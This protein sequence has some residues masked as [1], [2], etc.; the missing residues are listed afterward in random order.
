MA[1]N[2]TPSGSYDPQD[3]HFDGNQGSSPSQH[4]KQRG[5]VVFLCIL[6][7]TVF[8]VVRP[9]PFP[10]TFTR[11]LWLWIHRTVGDGAIVVAWIQIWEAVSGLESQE[12][13][14]YTAMAMV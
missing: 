3:G 7:Q 1:H 13:G 8:G 4:H 6:L 11:K 14:T 9:K 10:N 2:I 12:Q 5:L